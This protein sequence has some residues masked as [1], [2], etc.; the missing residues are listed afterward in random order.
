MV[1]ALLGSAFGHAA[2]LLTGDATVRPDA[3]A[4]VAMGTFYGGVA[5]APLSALVLVAELAGSYDLL[6][7]MRLTVAIAFVSL[8]NWTLYPAQRPGRAPPPPPAAP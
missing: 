6:V 4:L 3:F 7:P 1:G 2:A 8:R 5:H